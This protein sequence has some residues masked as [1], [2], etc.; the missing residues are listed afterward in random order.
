MKAGSALLCLMLMAALPSLRAQ[1]EGEAA[2]PPKPIPAPVKAR[3]TKLLPPGPIRFYSSDLYEYMDGGA[4]IYHVYGVVAVAHQES[5]TG[6]TAITA[7]IF[8]MGDPLKAFGIYAAERSPDYHFVAVGAEGYREQGLLNFLQDRYYVKLSGSGDLAKFAAAVSAKIGGG[9]SLPA[10]LDLLP[11]ENRVPRSEQYLVQ[12]PEGHEFLAP[13]L[14]AEYVLGGRKT[15]VLISIA[16]NAQEAN[17]R[18]ERLKQHYRRVGKT[19][20]VFFAH[21]RCAVLLL[22]PPGDIAEFRKALEAR[23]EKK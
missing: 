3:L 8:D 9:R 6:K 1:E 5:N 4:D 13:A 18:V 23:L 15:K 10:V 14:S 7:D 21:G 2:G 11:P 12:A 16:A 22:A 17:G 20:D 19:A